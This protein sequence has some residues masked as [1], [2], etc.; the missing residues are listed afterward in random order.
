MWHKRERGECGGDAGAGRSRRGGRVC[1]GFTLLELIICMAIM[2][3]LAAASIPAFKDF[4]SG[5][6]IRGSAQSIV[7]A[8]RA[9]RRIAIT[10]RVS[11]AVSVYMNTASGISNAVSYYDTA[12]TVKLQYMAKNVYL[13]DTGGANQVVTYTFNA[14]GGVAVTPSN[15]AIRVV[16]PLDKYIEVTTITA[17]G[18]VR[19]GQLE[20]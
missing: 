2:C 10:Q 7:A 20:Q 17:T 14:R 6:R 16:G 13:L 1:R 12:D 5:S 4:T 9:A 18:H 15:N 19:M 11:R 3:L 8:L